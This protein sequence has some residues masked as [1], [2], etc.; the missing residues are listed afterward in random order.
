[1]QNAKLYTR[2]LV[3]F[4]D[5]Q[6]AFASLFDAALQDPDA[7]APARAAHTLKGTA[8]NIG[9]TEVQAAAAAL[10]LA[11]HEGAGEA[12]RKA[13]LDAVVR[14]L[15]PVITGLNQLEDSQAHPGANVFTVD[16]RSEL[17]PELQ[18]L[19]K[20]LSR[21]DGEAADVLEH[22]QNKAEGTALARQLAAV[23][24]PLNNF[25]FDEALAQL[26]QI[27]TQ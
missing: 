1:M 11:C 16:M 23:E 2:L 6:G 10:E 15:E 4:R 9:A 5:S 18:K 12:I 26:K 22:I 17:Q 20:L 25:D 14:T 3:K 8:G 7:S 27:L 19:E 21:S 24:R 13:L